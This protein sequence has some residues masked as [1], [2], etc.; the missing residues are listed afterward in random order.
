M[1]DL[2]VSI[3][4]CEKKQRTFFEKHGVDKDVVDLRYKHY[5]GR[6]IDTFNRILEQRRQIKIDEARE[7]QRNNLRGF[8]PDQI[9]RRSAS[10]EPNLSVG[11]SP[12]AS[13]VKAKFQTA[14]K[15]PNISNSLAVPKGAF[16]TEFNTSKTGFNPSHAR[17]S[18][19]NM[20]DQ[21]GTVSQG[22]GGFE[23]NMDL[24]C[25]PMGQA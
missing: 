14:G 21:R 9:S 16:M 3:D 22:G 20:L 13:P 8:V 11:V 17:K 5:Q 2:G 24:A 7:Q 12:D 15:L 25:T 19:M 1:D 6:L 18:S 4:E 10:P 23:S